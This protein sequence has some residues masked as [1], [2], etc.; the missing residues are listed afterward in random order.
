MRR[1]V[2]ANL[3][4]ISKCVCVREIDKLI[5]RD[6]VIVFVCNIKTL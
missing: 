1:L 6:R 5:E 3:L 4:H 2:L